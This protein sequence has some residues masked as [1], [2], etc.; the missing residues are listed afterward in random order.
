MVP[1]EFNRDTAMVSDM[2]TVIGKDDEVIEAVIHG[3]AVDV[4]DDVGWFKIEDF[5]D[6]GAGYALG[7]SVLDIGAF[8]QGLYPS[9]VAIEGAE[10]IFTVSDLGFSFGGIL[11][12]TEAGDGDPVL[13][14]VD[15]LTSK[16]LMDSLP[17]DSVMDSQAFHGGEFVPVFGNNGIFGFWG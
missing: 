3:I 10:V 15:P 8:G 6:Q 14:G 1:Q 7:V 11:S 16:E 4:V 12:A 13:R 17:A 9:V 5:R 2:I